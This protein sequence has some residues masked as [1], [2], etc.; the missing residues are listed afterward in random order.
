MT[1]RIG[2]DAGDTFT[3]VCL[4]D[5]GT[6]RIDLWKLVST[7]DDPA[8]GIAQGIEQA[9]ARAG[10]ADAAARL[11]VCRAQSDP[12]AGVLGAREM[13]RLAGFESLISF[14]MGGAGTAVAP[15]D[16][17]VG[18]D[19]PMP[20]IHRIGIGGGSV[21]AADADGVLT[22]RPHGGG[23]TVT[24]A[25]LALRTLN[26]QRK[27]GGQVT[28][29]PDLAQGAIGVLAE[30][31][32]LDALAAAQAVLSAVTDTLAGDIRWWCSSGVATC[33][34]ARWWRSAEPGRCTRH[35]W[36]ARSTSLASWCRAMPACWARWGCC[37]ASCKRRFPPPCRC[38]SE[39]TRCRPLPR[40]SA[41]CATAPRS[42]SPSRPFRP[43]RAASPAASICAMSGAT[44]TFPC[45]CRTDR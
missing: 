40:R 36:R 42:G 12:S 41:C 45:R 30:A 15:L 24:D 35:G 32:G 31:L 14:D 33:A 39:P 25:H 2:V 43:A 1:W 7:P 26:P 20:D 19:A 22:L 38:R 10:L 27:L 13:A 18:A 23:P 16:G 8:R 37:W 21:A 29:H 5:D 28:L 9:V 34:T 11:P 4:F 6:G 44:M 17:G 3:D